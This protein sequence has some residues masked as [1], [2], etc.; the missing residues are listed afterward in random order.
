M[1]TIA[2]LTIGILAS[3]GVR[4]NIL[5]VLAPPLMATGSLMP[6]IGY[7]FGYGIAALFKLSQV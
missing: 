4:G 2:I 1:M 3:V 5:T 6:L 7:T